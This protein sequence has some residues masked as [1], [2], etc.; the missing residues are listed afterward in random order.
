MRQA[1][2]QL[3]RTND[4]GK[5]TPAGRARQQPDRER[6]PGPSREKGDRHAERPAACPARV[7]HQERQPTEAEEGDRGQDKASAAPSRKVASARRAP[8]ATTACSS[9]FCRNATRTAI[10]GL[11]GENAAPPISA[12]AARNQHPQKGGVP[13]QVRRDQLQALCE[14]YGVKPY[15]PQ[16]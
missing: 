2:R 11:G 10:A 14:S 5:S 16:G 6:V 9:V 4:L 15:W 8:V 3:E 1:T 7:A 12:E 13:F